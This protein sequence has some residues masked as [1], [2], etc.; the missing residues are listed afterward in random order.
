MFATIIIFALDPWINSMGLYNTFTVIGCLAVA[1][2]LLC[3][4]VILF[5]KKWRI[6]CAAQYEKMA[7]VQFDERGV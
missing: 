2:N 7:A 3:I 4:P 5:G 6:S 1:C